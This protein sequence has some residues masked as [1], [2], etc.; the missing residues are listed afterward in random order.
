[1]ASLDELFKKPNAPGKRKLESPSSLDPTELYHKSAKL[2]NGASARSNGRST[3]VEEES[4]LD[5]I[6]AGPALPPEDDIPDDEEGRFFGG[7]ITSGEKEVL[8]FI[9]AREGEEAEGEEII[10]VSWLRKMAV[11]FEKS[12]NKNAEMRAKFEG[13]PERYVRLSRPALFLMCC[14]YTDE[15]RRRFMASEADLDAEIKALSILSEHA[16]LYTEFA[17]LG[18]VGSLVSLLAHENTDIA[19]DAVEILG[20]LT[21]E[22]VEAEESQWKAL[23]DAML[24]ADVIDLLT[25]NLGRLIEKDESDRSGVYH[26][27]SVVENLLS[28]ADLAE[29]FG[30]KSNMLEWLLKRVQ[31]KETRV[32]QNKQYS[33]E[34]LAI[35]LQ[36]SQSNREKFAKMGGLDI[37]LQLLS[38]YRKKDP[39]K[40]SDEEEYV[41]N[42]FDCLTGMV[43]EEVGKEKFLEA[44]GV[45]L[46]QI[47]LKE[48]KMSKARA[49]RVLDHALAGSTGVAACERLV[50]TAGLKTIFGLFMK[51]Q[52]K[53]TVEH[54]LGIFSSLLRL[55]PGRSASRIRTLAKFVE[56]DYEKIGKLLQLRREHTERVSRV[57]Q[58]IAAEEQEMSGEEK[59]ER[60]AESLSRRFDAGLFSL[61]TLDVILAWLV[62]EDDGAGSTIRELM[63]K[64]GK[65]LGDLRRTLEGQLGGMEADEANGDA[66]AREVLQALIA[67]I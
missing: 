22:D 19:I 41:E 32:G 60:A 20:E 26:V 39:E 57:E 49:L 66:G 46:C 1:M 6:D 37:T 15:G 45:E 64:A 56:K 21:D 42:L 52:D 43:D 7:G 8:D 58:E 12:V 50:E 65:D 30:H 59:E 29:R 47:M 54:L 55:L 5:D 61:Q 62:A 16:E 36:S 34:L 9:D 67:C 35:L 31:E 28:Q 44:E 63:G 17:K 4:D 27:L 25:Q 11:N 2:S 13:S 38:A 33:A 14:G 10:D 3:T 51:K 40:D 53:A 23:V 18:C 24:E 48:G